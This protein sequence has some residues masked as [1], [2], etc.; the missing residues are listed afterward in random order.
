MYTPSMAK[1]TAISIKQLKK[2]GRYSDGGGLYL[3][4]RETADPDN[5]NKSWVFRWGAGGKNNMGLG[6]LKDV[7][8]AEAR[9]IAAAHHRMVSAG[10]DPRQAREQLRL[11]AQQLQDALTFE[12]AAKSL[13][14]LKRP[15]WKNK[16]HAEQ[17]T[18]TLT[19][20][21]YT[22]IG[23]TPCAEV[24]TEQV[25]NILRP[26][27]TT[28]NETATRV[29]GRIENV[30]D[31]AAVT[32]RRSGDNPARWKGKLEL[33]LPTISKRR[34]VTHHEAMPYPQ[35][36]TMFKAVANNPS[37]SAKALLFCVLTSTRSS[38]T[39]EAVWDE[40][41]LEKQLWI[42]PKD[43]MK[44]DKEHRVPLSDQAV[45]TLKTIARKG[46]SPYVFNGQSR[47]ERYAP[48][49]DMAML[50]YLQ[51]TLGHKKLTVHGFRS[52][53]RDWAGETTDHKREV[54]EQA[55]AH[56][57]ADQAEAAY[58]RGDYMEKRKVLMN[59]WADYCYGV[60]AYAPAEAP[61]AQTTASGSA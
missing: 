14:E 52:S 6:T 31:W 42:I 16:K 54:I 3:Q 13:I 59:D 41:D 47:T 36:P 48:L 35:V 1:L 50:N 33:L 53:F 39:R 9:N 34:R 17:W 60:G 18:N 5:P 4:V 11:E 23:S 40:I 55:L 61:T 43:R 46:D 28:K 25:L 56:Q 21:A 2:T 19:S 30:L 38:E 51:K 27:W 22:E 12:E 57:L 44:K 29:R 58:Q 8:L 37:L 15:T 10:Q 26:I 7:P 49:S 24:T 45:A 32:E 20:Y